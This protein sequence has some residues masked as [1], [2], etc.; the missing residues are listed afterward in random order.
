MVAR[1]V[2]KPASSY[3]FRQLE[4]LWISAGGDARD[5]P[6]AAAVALAESAGN[7]N[8]QDRNTNGTIDRGLWQ[9][10]SVHGRLSTTNVAANAKAAVQIHKKSGWDPWVTYKNGA[11]KAHLSNTGLP[12]NPNALQALEDLGVVHGPHSETPITKTIEKAAGG[13][14]EAGKAIDEAPRKGAEAVAKAFQKKWLE[15][16]VTLILVLA[17]ALLLVYGVAVAVR[18]RESAFSLPK[19]PAVVPV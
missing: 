17:G 8:A 4:E 15:L 10:N 2:N 9:I 5:A 7:P 18:P 3:T 11:Y 13:P 12:T 14:A 6:T 16:G 1:T 19:M